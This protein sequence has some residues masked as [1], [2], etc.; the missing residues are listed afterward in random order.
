MVHDALYDTMRSSAPEDDTPLIVQNSSN[1]FSE[2]E[3][4]P[5]HRGYK[6]G[7]RAGGSACVGGGGG[8]GGQGNA[9]A[10][11]VVGECASLPAAHRRP[12]IIGEPAT[13]KE[14]I[15]LCLSFFVLLSSVAVLGILIYIL[16]R[17][18]EDRKYSYVNPDY[19]YHIPAVVETVTTCI[20]TGV[21]LVICT[22]YPSVQEKMD[23][24]N[25]RRV[26]TLVILMM[27][28][29]SVLTAVLIC[30]GY[31]IGV[32]R[33][34]IAAAFRSALLGTLLITFMIRSCSEE[35]LHVNTT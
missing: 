2:P 15:I 33:V 32:E 1:I 21:A 12:E 25:G 13:V 3:A 30:S 17:I 22:H 27:F 6:G 8:G 14:V 26:W 11:I 19:R 5:R 10:S 31:P 7:S 9:T 20:I 4:P 24:P 16:V 23:G 34:G 28:T 18:N 29:T 35:K